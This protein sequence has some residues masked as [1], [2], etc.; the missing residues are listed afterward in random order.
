MG[1]IEVKEMNGLSYIGLKKCVPT[2]KL[3]FFF[4]KSYKILQNQIKDLSEKNIYF[5]RYSNIDWDT[6]E[7]EKSFLGFFKAML[8]KFYVEVAISTAE[9]PN[10]LPSDV[11]YLE[12]ESYPKTLQTVHKGPY[13]KVADTYKKMAE[14]ASENNLELA[15]ETFEIYLNDPRVVTQEELETLMVIPLK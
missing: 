9:K 5:A 14:Y 10:D 3:P 15:N 12:F 1:K 4:K 11:N 6:V 8:K 2:F 13:H 7:C